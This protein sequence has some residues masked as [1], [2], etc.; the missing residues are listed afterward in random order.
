M[1]DLNKKSWIPVYCLLLDCFA[2]P[3]FYLAGELASD[4][5]NNLRYCD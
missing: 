1:K 5:R 3:P 4:I 2:P